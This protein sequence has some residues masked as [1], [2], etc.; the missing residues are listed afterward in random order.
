MKYELFVLLYVIIKCNLF[1]WWQSLIFSSHYVQPLL[2]SPVSHDPSEIIVMCWF[3]AHI[4]Y[5]SQCRK[6]WKYCCLIVFI[7]TNFFQ[8]LHIKWPNV[9]RLVI[10]LNICISKINIL[11]NFLF[12]KFTISTKISSKTVCN[13]SCDT[14]DLSNECYKFSFVITG[15]NYIFKYITIE[16]S[17]FKNIAIIFTILL[18]F[19]VIK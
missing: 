1:L 2:Q 9:T 8:P 14:E 16:N 18:F 4:S 10:L 5:Y 12:M 17:S 7:F 13:G 6:H 3:G 19:T 11:W 15:I